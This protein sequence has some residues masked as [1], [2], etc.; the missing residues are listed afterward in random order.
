MEQNKTKAVQLKTQHNI[1]ITRT[2]N[3]TTNTKYTINGT[4]KPAFEKANDKQNET[5]KQLEINRI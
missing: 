2:Y 3:N 5:H 1:H 4:C